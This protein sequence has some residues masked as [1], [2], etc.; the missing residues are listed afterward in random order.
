MPLPAWAKP[1]QNTVPPAWAK[2]IEAQ[3]QPE[4]M[5]QERD[6]PQW[7]EES[8]NLYGLYGAGRAILQTGLE[9]GGQ[10]LGAAGG[11]AL[12]GPVG[13][14]AGSGL[15]YASGKR[16]GEKII[17]ALDTAVGEPAQTPQSESFAKDV[18]I[19]AA[20]GGA[21]SLIGKGAARLVPE[22]VIN[23]LY[24][25]SLKM[26]TTMAPAERSAA[27]ATGLKEGAIPTE[28]IGVF[29]KW[30]GMKGHDQIVN[31]ITQLDDGVSGIIERAMTKG[32]TVS[33]RTVASGLEDMIAK[34]QRLE[35]V[36]PAF[37]EAI[38][39]V[40]T[41][42]LSG[43]DAI[44][45]KTAQEM[46]RHIYKVYQDYYGAPDAIGAYIQG[47]KALASG[48]KSELEK[49]Y[50]QISALNMEEGQLLNFLDPFNRAIGRIANRDIVGLGMQVAP[51]TGAALGGQPAAFAS[52]IAKLADT[53]AIKA[54]LAILLNR[55]KE[56]GTSQVRQAIGATTP[57]AMIAR[58][59]ALSPPNTQNALA[60][61]GE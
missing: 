11:A 51:T 2:P 15:G 30:M 34:G 10:A 24:A 12:A 40:K 45:V 52:S 9:A 27:I 8:P 56:S 33:A 20:M 60:T 61:Q 5:A 1:I 46:K 57:T 13:M 41:E 48:L 50:P 49:Q 42:F 16:A 21:G 32:D 23:K 44:P 19:G 22:S 53:P 14:I 43:P 35:K 18:A 47:K 25:S 39:K 38:K 26:P 28:S 6:V 29:G 3:P 4:V 55:A 54:R 31:K 58:G 36:D 17:G 59:N 7:G 37:L